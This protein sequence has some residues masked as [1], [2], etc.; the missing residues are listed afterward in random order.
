[1]RFQCERII[2]GIENR[3]SKNGN[4]YIII[5]FLDDN[6]KTFSCV[7]NVPLPDDVKQLDLV[8]VEFEIIFTSKNIYMRVNKIWKD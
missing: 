6:G 1:M 5:H 4:E 8:N 3:K 7:S 2:T